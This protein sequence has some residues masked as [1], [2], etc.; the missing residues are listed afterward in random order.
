MSAFGSQSMA[1]TL[2]RVLMRSAANAMRDADRSA[3]HY[4]PGFNPAKAASQHAALAELV[5]ASGAEIEWI[6]DKADGLSDSVFTHD[7]SLMTGRGALILSMGK[8]LRAREPSLHE[9]TYTRLG[10]PILGRVEAPG[11][12]EGGDC[13]WVDART[14]AIGRGVRSNQEGIQQVSNLLTPLGVSVY[15]FDLPLWQGEEACLHL[16]SVISPLAD[17][18]ALVYSPLLPAPFYQM[19]KARGIRLV[20]GDAE[21]FAA[22]NGLSLNVLPTSPL[23]VIAVAGFPKTKAAMEA[24]GCMVEV[25]E[26]DAL[27]IA[28]EGG[29]TCLTRPI[30]RQ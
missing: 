21:E 25:F 5:A 29:P 23:N 13:V 10:I 30:L 27:C 24:A 1:A 22:S 18:L 7:P 2:R 9:E 20:E 26:A 17:D 16:M 11:Q 15:G 6:E 4:G 3:W 14:L 19:L 28:C 12:V 8:P